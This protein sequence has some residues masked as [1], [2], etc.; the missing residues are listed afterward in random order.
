MG[1]T[2]YQTW[3][4]CMGR[5]V[6]HYRG[7]SQWPR[8]LS[9]RPWSLGRWDRRFESRLRHGSVSSSI[10]HHHRHHLPLAILSSTLYSA[11]TEKAS[12]K[13]LLEKWH[14]PVN[15]R[16]VKDHTDPKTK[17]A[18]TEIL[19]LN[20][21]NYGLFMF[22]LMLTLRDIPTHNTSSLRWRLLHRTAWRTVPR[23]VGA[24]ATLI[25]WWPFKP[26]FVEHLFSGGWEERI[27]Y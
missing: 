8:G 23:H 20:I 24:S 26:T 14:D 1:K 4:Q 3:S 16:V 9:R 5:L 7:R 6:R 21:P 12:W 15:V 13:K 18:E 2:I 22:M 10:H 25:I 17:N 27:L 19:L 11:A